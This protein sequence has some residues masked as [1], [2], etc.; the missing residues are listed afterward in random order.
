MNCVANDNDL[1]PRV[2]VADLDAEA[3]LKERRE[4]I[5]GNIDSGNLMTA[6]DELCTLADFHALGSVSSE[7]VV[8]TVNAEF[9]MSDGAQALL[10][11]GATELAETAAREYEFS[12]ENWEHFQY[13]VIERFE[14]ACSELGIAIS[15]R[16]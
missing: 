10:D 4:R 14:N 3:A 9:E 11:R 15:R 16:R 8:E 13:I 7:D 1:G 6:L 12:D 2:G 5:K